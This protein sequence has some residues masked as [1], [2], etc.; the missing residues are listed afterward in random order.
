[1]DNSERIIR[2]E[3]FKMQDGEYKALVEVNDEPEELIGIPAH[4]AI[5]IPMALQMLRG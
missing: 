4:L 3:I 5:Q 2:V 1:M